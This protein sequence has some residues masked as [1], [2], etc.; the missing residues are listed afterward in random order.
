MRS[1]IVWSWFVRRR[2]EATASR[3]GRLGWVMSNVSPISRRSIHPD[4]QDGAPRVAAPSNRPPGG[5]SASGIPARRFNAQEVPIGQLQMEFLVALG[6][7]KPNQDIAKLDRL[8]DAYSGPYHA[9][10]QTISVPPQFRMNTGFNQ[11]NA[12]AHRKEVVAIACKAHVQGAEAALGGYATPKQLTAVT[13]ALIDAGKLKPG[14]Q[15]TLGTRIRE[16]QW[17]YGI[18]VDCAGYTRHAMSALGKGDGLLPAGTEAFRGLGANSKFIAR[19]PESVE[20]GDVMTLHPHGET[21]HNVV[22]RRR[23]VVDTMTPARRRELLATLGEPGTPCPS[24]AE[25]FLKQPGPIHA[26]QVDSSWGAG[27]HG[28][29]AGGYRCDTWLYNEST[30]EWGYINKHDTPPTFHTSSQGP[31]D[32]PARAWRHR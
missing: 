3:S 1:E 14:P 26:I 2:N 25:A 17:E 13:Q 28:D 16:M 6:A 7:T 20:T 15:A 5:A 30:K 23:E 32:E 9:E 27:A 11:K 4:P 31:H 18:G 10:G 8:R 12:D 19:K 29:A 21:G 24:K 22:V